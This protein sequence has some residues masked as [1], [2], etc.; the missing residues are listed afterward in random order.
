MVDSLGLFVNTHCLGMSLPSFC[1]VAEYCHLPTLWHCFFFL[2]PLIGPSVGT[3]PKQDQSSSWEF[4]RTL[5]GE[6]ERE[7][8][9][10]KHK[11]R[12]SFSRGFCTVLCNLVRSGSNHMDWETKRKRWSRYIERRWKQRLSKFSVISQ[13]LILF[14]RPLDS[15]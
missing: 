5:V 6:K 15:A 1:W 7:Q 14:R 12:L 10:P 3:W 9:R 11:I 13:S 2:S 8:R 4:W